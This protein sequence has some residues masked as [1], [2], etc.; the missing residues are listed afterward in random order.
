[1]KRNFKKN[2][3]CIFGYGLVVAIIIDIVSIIA[4]FG[5]SIMTMFGFEYT[6]VKS[7]ILFFIVV[8]ILGFPLETLAKSLPKA[9]LSI[10]K[11]SLIKAKILFVIMDTC[12][13]AIT[14]KIVDNKMDDVSATNLSILVISFIF[15]I[16]SISDLKVNDD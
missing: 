6:S 4:I 13:T 5:G 11:I 16:L 2:I 14:M 15:A 1:M 12:S 3:T 10:N 7:I 9:M 8:S